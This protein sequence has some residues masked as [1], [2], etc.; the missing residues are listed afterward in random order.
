MQKRKISFY[1]FSLTDAVDYTLAEPNVY[2]ADK[3]DAYLDGEKGCGKT[4]KFCA[5][6][7]K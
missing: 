2:I 1:S 6:T 5:L 4:L 7:T 3:F